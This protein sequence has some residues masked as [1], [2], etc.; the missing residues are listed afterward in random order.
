[1]LDF[2]AKTPDYRVVH[3]N[4][5]GHGA[6][7]IGHDVPEGELDAAHAAPGHGRRPLLGRHPR[8][9]RAL[10]QRERV[11]ADFRR[12]ME[13]ASGLDLSAFF[14]QWLYRGGVP[15]VDGTWRWDAA[16]KQVIVELR[17]TQPGEP[18]HLPIDVGITVPGARA[19]V[20]HADLAGQSASFSFPAAQ[21]P[22]AVK[23]DPDVRL[24]FDGH[25][26]KKP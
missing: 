12:A 21:G 13:R 22:I 5:V 20:E 11:H 6:G 14:Q 16:A 7:H 15:R 18:F 3:E 8:L 26:V 4:L 9:L 17:Q 2:Y 19:R 23:L 10:S 24:L 1:M 25:L